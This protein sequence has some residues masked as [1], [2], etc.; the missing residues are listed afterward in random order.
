MGIPL[1]KIGQWVEDN[2]EQTLP[3]YRLPLAQH[4]HLKST[5]MLERVN[6]G[7]KRL[8]LLVRIFPNAASCLRLVRSLAIEIHEGWVEATRYLNMAQLSEHRKE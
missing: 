3:F 4:K 8:T 7:F 6:E 1:R 2:I 5:N